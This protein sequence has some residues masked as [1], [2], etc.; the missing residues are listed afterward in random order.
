[1]QVLAAAGVS[2]GFIRKKG[3]LPKPCGLGTLESGLVEKVLAR[4]LAPDLKS[5]EAL[6]A[7]EQC[8]I[9]CR[10]SALVFPSEVLGA[11]YNGDV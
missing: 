4:I 3:Q 5:I 2:A 6:I 1:M 7:A 8:C 9:E 11:G 10:W